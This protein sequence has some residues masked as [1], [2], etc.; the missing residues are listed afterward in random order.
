MDIREY[1]EKRNLIE[2]NYQARLRDARELMSQAEQICD[3]EI[4]KLNQE[5]RETK[6]S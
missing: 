4:E 2:L 3:E 1:K 6:D 5:R